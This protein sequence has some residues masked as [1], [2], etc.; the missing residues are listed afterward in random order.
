MSETFCGI[1]RHTTGEGTGHEVWC[2]VYTGIP[3]PGVNP[4]DMQPAAQSPLNMLQ[5]FA[6]LVAPAQSP[7][8]SL[9]QPPPI[10]GLRAMVAQDGYEVAKLYREARERILQEL[11]MQLEVNYRLGRDLMEA[12]MEAQDLKRQLKERDEMVDLL[13]QVP[14]EPWKPPKTS[15]DEDVPF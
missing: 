2:P 12:R 6:G 15:I 8:P 4:Q 13:S 9:Q 11:R 14:P 1:C 3:V 7:V 5:Q 10:A